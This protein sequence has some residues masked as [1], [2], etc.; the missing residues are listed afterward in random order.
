MRRRSRNSPIF[1]L[2]LGLLDIVYVSFVYVSF[3]AVTACDSSAM[4]R[5][6]LDWVAETS[7]SMFADVF[8]VE[9]ASDE[10][11]ERAG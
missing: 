6:Q 1:I 4:I 5:K 11:G 7:Y 3:A 2:W 10:V 8:E 9:I